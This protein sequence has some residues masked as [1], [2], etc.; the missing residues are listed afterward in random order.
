MSLAHR[1]FSIVV[2]ALL[3][4]CF[5]SAQQPTSSGATVVPRL[6]NFSG[7]ATD[8]EGKTIAGVTGVTF[9]IYREQQGG[10]PL[11]IETQSVQADSK[12]NYTVQL[13]ATKPDGLPIDLF[14]SGEAR[15]LGI[16]INGAEEQPRVLLLSVPYALKA[17]D[18]ET[19]GGLPASAFVLA[20]PAPGE[21]T[22]NSVAPPSNSSSASHQVS[23]QASPKGTSDVTTSGGTVNAV[24]LFT[25]ATNVQNSIL[26]QTGTSAVNVAGTLKMPATGTASATAGKNS[27]AQ[28]YVA[29][30]F[31]KTTGTAVP[32]TFQLQAEPA[33]NDTSTASGTLNL[34][35]ATGANKP[36]ETGL[37]ISSKG[38]ITFASG[39]TF[40]GVSTITAVTAGT[41][42]TGGGT[43]G[44]VKLNLNTSALNSL[45]ARLG[46]TNNFIGNQS[47]QGGTFTAGT[48]VSQSATAAVVATGSDSHNISLYPSLAAGD[49]NGIV[50]AGDQALISSNGTPGGASGGFVIAPWENAMSG[51]R[52]DSNGIFSMYPSLII[53][54]PA[55][56]IEPLLVAGA[57]GEGCVINFSGDLSCSGT[58]NAAVPVDDGKRWVAMSAIESPVNWFE[59]AG[60]AKLVNGVATIQLDPTFIQTVNTSMDYKVFPVP[61]GDCKGLYVTNKTETSFEVHESGGGTSTVEF[62]YRIMAVRKK[63]ETVRFADRTHVM[64]SIRRRRDHQMRSPAESQPRLPAG[65]K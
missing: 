50:Q 33:G 49:Y 53:T 2:A 31:N 1:L 64:E 19:V 22:S 57:P 36:A 40:P 17:A 30:V 39:Q 44:N 12:G 45:Y 10:A 9:A 38:L 65:E 11:W 47:V 26:T 61:N 28:T 34:M 41:D 3:F 27:Q 63:Y 21:A 8:G 52:M 37:K 20:K 43:S 48:G 51:M 24:P 55:S 42:L 25:T 14:A 6:V 4:G 23:S 13:G 54:S 5:V 35:Y 7:K 15:W 32:Q 18:A 59:D 62:D 29:S 56:N 16:S 58:K 60:S 46:A